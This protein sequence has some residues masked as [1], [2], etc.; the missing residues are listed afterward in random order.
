MDSNLMSF[1]MI[2]HSTFVPPAHPLTQYS[3]E[4]LKL[5]TGKEATF[6]VMVGAPT[7]V[8]EL[9]DG[10][11]SPV[12]VIGLPTLAPPAPEALDVGLAELDDDDAQYGPHS[13]RMGLET[14]PWPDTTKP[15]PPAL[16]SAVAVVE[17]DLGRM[18]A[19][20]EDASMGE[21]MKAVQAIRE[22]N[23]KVTDD[24]ERAAGREAA[25]R[26]AMLL[27]GE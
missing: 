1:I 21:I 9:L 26:L 11:L 16:A 20:D 4:D 5:D 25:A 17:R 15:L 18:M 14:H 24:D 10:R 13:L 12:S 23:M 2:L 6:V 19:G 7:S 8:L 3:T 22:F 27:A